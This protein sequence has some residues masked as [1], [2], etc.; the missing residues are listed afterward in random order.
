M[1]KEEFMRKYSGKFQELKYISFLKEDDLLTTVVTDNPEKYVDV[2]SQC[3]NL[4]NICIETTGDADYYRTVTKFIEKCNDTVTISNGTVGK[5]TKEE[6]LKAE[7]IIEEVVEK[8]DPKWTEKQ[9]VAFVHYEMGKLI[10]YTPDF[11]FSGKYVGAKMAEDARNIWKSI[12][13]GKSVCNGVTAIQRNILSRIGI[14]TRELSS[15]PHSFLLI[16]T[17][18]GN[19]ITDATWD[20]TNTLFEARPMYFGKTYE[21]L[22]EIDR[23]FSKAHRLE[24][25]PEN[26]IQI[27]ETELRE[28]YYSIGITTEDRKFKLPILDKVNEISAQ[29]FKS[30]KQKID[31][32][33]KIFT[34]DF[35][36]QAIHLSESRSML[37]NCITTLGIDRKKLTTKFVYSKDDEE[38]EKAYLC[39]H[40]NEDEMRENISILNI[41]EM[42]FENLSLQDFDKSYKTH[43]EDTREPFWK[44]YLNREMVSKQIEPDR[45]N[46]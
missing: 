10:S 6:F 12:D 33:F 36:K 1:N 25:P 32:L 19:I 9:K 2:A 8:I 23:P 35:S 29:H 38:C 26:V 7:K 3:E 27:S 39:I 15:G 41:E 46:E 43:E 13:S 17:E 18:K 5:A 31:A 11:C 20:L 16:E 34:K 42:K 45:I 30:D 44:K 24:Q 37:E 22:Q 4:R 40:L 21:E 28:I 14:K